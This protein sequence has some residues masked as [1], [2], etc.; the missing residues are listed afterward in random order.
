M[1]ARDILQGMPPEFTYKEFTQE[2]NK[3]EYKDLFID[4]RGLC[5][6]KVLLR[7]CKGRY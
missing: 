4:N 7:I 3:K 2:L 5:T 6:E 1:S